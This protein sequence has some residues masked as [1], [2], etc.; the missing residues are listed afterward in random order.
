MSF[1]ESTLNF[2]VEFRV[3]KSNYLQTILDSTLGS[4]T[5][6]ICCSYQQGDENLLPPRGVW[7]SVRIKNYESAF[8]SVTGDIKY[9]PEPVHFM[10]FVTRNSEMRRLRTADYSCNIKDYF[11]QFCEGGSATV[12]M[13]IKLFGSPPPPTKTIEVEPFSLESH[14]ESWLA[15]GDGDVTFIVGAQKAHVRAHS[16]FIRHTIEIPIIHEDMREGASNEIIM[17]DIDPNVFRAF[18]NFVYTGRVKHWHMKQHCLALLAL[19]DRLGLMSRL[20]TLSFSAIPFPPSHFASRRRYDLPRLRDL[21]QNFV[22]THGPLSAA[23]S[24]ELLLAADAYRAP[25][26]REAALDAYAA[27]PEAAAAG[28]GLD[29]LPEDLLRECLR[30]APIRKRRRDEATAAGWPE[31]VHGGPEA[32]GWRRRCGGVEASLEVLKRIE[33]NLAQLSQPRHPDVLASPPP[34]GPPARP[35]P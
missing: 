2:T 10:S 23:N 32:R 6:E 33:E 20:G 35:S 9:G 30:T 5:F 29:A 7:V 27:N 28:P 22:L 26:L 12:N 3:D 24:C 1:Q 31:E 34:R 21:C 25:R 13:T 14:M 19:G 18:L 8:F 17:P 4:K 11:A 15:K 16:S